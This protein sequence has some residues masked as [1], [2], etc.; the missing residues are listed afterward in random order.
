MYFAKLL[1]GLKAELSWIVN[2][3]QRGIVKVCTGS[4]G[5]AVQPFIKPKT[6]QSFVCRFGV[7]KGQP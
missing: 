3:L 1:G 4:I 6:V 2:I 7:L 5:R